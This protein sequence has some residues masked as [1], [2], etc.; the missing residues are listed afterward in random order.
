MYNIHFTKYVREE[1]VGIAKLVKVVCSLY[2]SETKVL[3]MNSSLSCDDPTLSSMPTH[4]PIYFNLNTI[5][6]LKRV[7]KQTMYSQPDLPAHEAL[8]VLRTHW[9]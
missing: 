9:T 4:F 6:T 7:E 1:F 3:D 8:A 5:I 2:S